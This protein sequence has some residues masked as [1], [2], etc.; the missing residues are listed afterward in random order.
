[1]RHIKVRVFLSKDSRTKH[2]IILCGERA[3]SDEESS[4]SSVNYS[5]DSYQQH[6]DD[7]RYQKN[8]L[9]QSRT[10]GGNISLKISAKAETLGSSN[11]R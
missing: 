11:V 3:A 10:A 7:L 5:L 1:M 8:S 9:Q 6:T 2:E 4:E